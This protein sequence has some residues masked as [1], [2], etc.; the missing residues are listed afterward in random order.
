MEWLFS[1]LS[2]MMDATHNS[3]YWAFVIPIPIRAESAAVVL[4]ILM[5]LVLLKVL[6]RQRDPGLDMSVI[7]V[8]WLRDT[9]VELNLHQAKDHFGR[10]FP[11][12]TTKTRTTR[13]LKVSVRR[14]GRRTRS[15]ICIVRVGQSDAEG[16]LSVSRGLKGRLGLDEK[17]NVRLSWPWWHIWSYTAGNPDPNIAIQWRLGALFCLV[18]I[19]LPKLLDIFLSR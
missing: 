3:N 16:V 1:F 14:P 19:V 13:T 12:A 7:E 4:L 2:R 8:A 18:G 10:Y 9:E 5:G 17:A 15:A 11:E 6:A